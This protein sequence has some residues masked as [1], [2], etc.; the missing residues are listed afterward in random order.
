VSGTALVAGAALCAL[1]LTPTAALAVPAPT[2]AARTAGLIDANTGQQLY[3][4]DG[5]EPVPIAS[6]TKIMTAL[7]T[8][9]HVRHLD[10]VFTQ[11]DWVAAPADSQI[12]LAPGER[13]TVH[14]LLLALLLPSADDAAEDLAFNVGGGSVA[15]FVAMMNA[16]A[17][18]LG[19]THTH[20]STP[21]GF[22]D[23]GNY[24]TAFDLDKLAAYALANSRLLARIVALPRATLMT[25]PEHHVVNRNDLLGRVPWIT[26]VKTGHTAGAG[27]ALVLSGT[28]DG[29]TLIGAVLGTSSIAARDRAALALLDYGFAEFRLATPVVAGQVLARPRVRNVPG[30]HAALV[31]AAGFEQVVPRADRLRVKVSLSRRLTGPMRRGTLAGHALVLVGSHVVA[32]LPL[33]LGRA[34]P[35]PPPGSTGLIGGVG[36]LALL[37][38]AVLVGGYLGLRRALRLRLTRRDRLEAG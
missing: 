18:R 33:R 15:R 16:E 19:L 4:V 21:I 8:L 30:A 24:S 3:G 5:D 34:L 2:L 12:G 35:A 36:L 7:I 11:N 25:G 38:V 1:L 14:D 20:Y 22:D 29:M 10:T 17:V 6:T 26:G 13:M 28:R 9:E 23:P 27:Y 32:R 31:A 37:A